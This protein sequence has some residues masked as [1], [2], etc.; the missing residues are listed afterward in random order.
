[1]LRSKMT[2]R[3]EVILR[4]VLVGGT[5]CLDRLEPTADRVWLARTVLCDRYG[6]LGV[7]CSELDL[8]VERKSQPCDILEVSHKAGRYDGRIRS[9]LTL[10]ARCQGMQLER[11]VALR[12]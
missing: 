9:R 5:E 8:L 3:P 7:P 2:D 11:A 4:A 6:W 1:M 12:W 10:R